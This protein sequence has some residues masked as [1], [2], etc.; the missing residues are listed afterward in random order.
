MK[1][2]EEKEERITNK[3]QTKGNQPSLGFNINKN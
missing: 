1:D 2:N 3:A